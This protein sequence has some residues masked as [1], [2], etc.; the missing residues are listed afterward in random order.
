M[1]KVA[2]SRTEASISLR[3]RNCMDTVPTAQDLPGVMVCRFAF[4]FTFAFSFDIPFA[5]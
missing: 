4:A 5:A 2:H 3:T 1:R